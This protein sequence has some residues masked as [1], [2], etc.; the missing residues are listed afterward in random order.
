MADRAFVVGIS[1][2][3]GAGKSKLMQLLLNDFKQAQA[4]YY[5]RYDPGMTEMQ[6]QDWSARQGDP[7]E[8]VLFGLVEALRQRTQVPAGGRTRAPV[9]FE[10]SFGRAHCASGAFIDFLIWIDTPLD[11]ALARA[12]LVFLNAAQRDRTPNAAQ[13]FIGWQTGYML[14]YPI[15]RKVYL[16]QSKLVASAAD[17]VLDGL[18]SA[19]EW[20]ATVRQALSARGV[21]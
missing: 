4:I 19:E 17:L 8:F 6:I 5:D 13:N 3:P 21:G 16:N 7:N 15:I 2:I 12:N 10:T 14:D 9:F 11:V 1:G 18:K 20:A